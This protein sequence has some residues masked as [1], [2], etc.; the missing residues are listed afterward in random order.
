MIKNMRPTGKVLSFD[1]KPWCRVWEAETEAGYRVEVHVHR[2]QVPIDS[3]AC[4][5]L[6]K[7]L[8][9]MNPPEEIVQRFEVGDSIGDECERCRD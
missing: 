8:E 2:V 9:E 5:E 4:D 3:P 6:A 1:G 7:A